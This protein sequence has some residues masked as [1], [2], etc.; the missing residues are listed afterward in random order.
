MTGNP[1]KAA[2]AG[3]TLEQRVEIETPEQVVFSHTIAGVGSRSAAALI[4]VLIMIALYVAVVALY[5]VADAS[6]GVSLPGFDTA[7]WLMAVVI[8][9]AFAVTWGY[10]VLFEA[11]ADGRTPGKMMMGLRVVQDGGYSI[12]FAASA[13]RN[14]V[15]IVDFIPGFYAVGIAAILFSRTGKRLGDHAAGT[16]VVR[17]RAV[18]APAAPAPATAEA[19][20]RANVVSTQL[21]DEEYAL[22][23]RYLG[24]R[25]TLE[26]AVRKSFDERL[27]TRLADRIPAGDGEFSG[28]LAAL[29][30]AERALRARGVAS[31]S[32]T[33][34]AREQHAIVASSASR[35]QAF[36]S[37][38]SAAQSRGIKKLS[39]EE[40]A[41]LAARYREASTDLARLSTASRGRDS[42]AAFFLTRLVARGHN[43]LYRRRELLPLVIYQYVFLDVPREVRRSWRHIGL[44]ALLLFGP[45]FVSH[46]TVARNPSVAPSLV[47]EGFVEHAQKALEREAR[48]QGYISDSSASDGSATFASGVATNNVQVSFLAFALGITAGIGTAWVLF[49]N[50]VSIGAALGTFQAYGAL[51]QIMAFVMGHGVLELTAICF[52]GGAGF[53]IGSAFLLPGAL[54]RREA[55]V[56]RGRRAIRLVAAAALFLIVAGAIEGFV[57]PRNLPLG[58]AIAVGAISGVFGLIFVMWGRKRAQGAPEEEFAYNEARA[59]SSM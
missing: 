18:A 51:H 30:A 11:L 54:T 10:Y 46:Y 52:A 53:L 2:R 25:S 32:D 5:T 20:E 43:L 4:D 34:A 28:R 47:G 58:Q 31:R 24:R 6:L 48:G 1:A 13:V 40:V 3:S 19:A 12:S 36:A 21:S 39:E 8:V 45:M 7:E 41:D 17:E 37:A 42:D 38:V 50:G 23:D 49:T 29:H 57:S 33:G 55:L 27:A 16:I 44:A 35:W 56:V 15:R 26:P 22:L 59:F 14:V 9:L